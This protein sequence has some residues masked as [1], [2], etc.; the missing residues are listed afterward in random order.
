MI[1]HASPNPK[2]WVLREDPNGPYR[3]GVIANG[4]RGL[5]KPVPLDRTC[6]QMKLSSEALCLCEGMDKSMPNTSQTVQWAAEFAL[7]TLNNRIQEQYTA[8]LRSKPGALASGFHGYG[9]C[10]RYIGT[11]IMYARHTVT[12]REQ[13]LIFSLLAMPFD[14][15]TVEIFDVQ[16]S[17]AMKKNAKGITL[18]N[19]IRVSPFNK[20]E[21]CTD[22]GVDPSLCA[23]HA[24]QQN[25]TLWRNELY[26][27]IAS[28]ENFKLKPQTQIL[29]QPCLTIISR[30]RRHGKAYLRMAIKTYE[31]VNACPDVTYKLIIS[32]KKL[33][34]TRISLKHP[35]SVSLL[36]RTVTFLLT[37]NVE[38]ASERFIPTFQFEKRKW[39]KK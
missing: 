11:G 13:K 34:E 39:R 4:L 5:F 31:A 32:F 12:G 9:A 27:K 18:T 26:S 24:N 35:K 22:K 10:Q 20:Y 3:K 25:N 29:D 7:G 2:N 6:E 14:R 38:K 19:L 36:P 21:K 23:C 8:A 15:K 16:L 28:Q 17:Y 30:V 33:R 37:A 1:Q